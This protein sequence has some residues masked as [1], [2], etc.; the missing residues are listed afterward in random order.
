MTAVVRDSKRPLCMYEARCLLSFANCHSPSTSL[1]CIARSSAA[2]FPS[3]Q[4]A[5]LLHTSVQHVAL[6]H[7]LP[8]SLTS[9]LAFGSLPF[10]EPCGD[11]F[12]LSLSCLLTSAAV[13][14]A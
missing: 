13:W 6:S 2:N 10:D 3:I 7:S 1:R 14:R 12:A 8:L 9:T 5:Y 11:T 4:P